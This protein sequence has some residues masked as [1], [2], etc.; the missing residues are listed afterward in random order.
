M[1]IGSLLKQKLPKGGDIPATLNAGEWKA[2]F[3]IL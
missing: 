1:R 2:G 3:S